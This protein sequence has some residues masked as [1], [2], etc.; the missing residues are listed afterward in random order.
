MGH[1]RP[2]C[3]GQTHALRGGSCGASQWAASSGSE[4]QRRRKRTGL[5]DLPIPRPVHY[6]HRATAQPL[7]PTATGS[8]TFQ[9]RVLDPQNGGPKH[10]RLTGCPAYT[11]P[12]SMA[13]RRCHRSS[14][15]SLAAPAEARAC[16]GA[17]SPSLVVEATRSPAKQLWTLTPSFGLCC[18]EAQAAHPQGCIGRGGRHPPPPPGRP[19]YAQ[20]LSPQR[21]A[22]A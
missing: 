2:S 4:Q 8:R 12:C 15:L 11:R 3:R 16:T 22:P 21:Q 18:P 9:S 5:R 14:A 7:F 1:T 13:K 17:G 19:A 10:D 20:S 6:C